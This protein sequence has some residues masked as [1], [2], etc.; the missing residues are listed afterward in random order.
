MEDRM[1]SAAI[2]LIRLLV[3]WVFFI[4]GI[5]KFR[6]WDDL[7]VG[8]FATIGIPAVTAIRFSAIRLLI[9]IRILA[10]IFDEVSSAL[11]TFSTGSASTT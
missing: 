10:C 1:Y 9:Y 11:S 8:R 4:E 6:W 7:G 3:G 2:V 5:L